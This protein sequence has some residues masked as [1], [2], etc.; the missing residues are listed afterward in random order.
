MVAIWHALDVREL[1]HLRQIRAYD[2][3]HCGEKFVRF[4][5]SMCNPPG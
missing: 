1:R 2:G 3:L 4:D 5:V